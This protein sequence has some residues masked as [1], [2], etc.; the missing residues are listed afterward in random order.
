M[1]L[2]KLHFLSLFFYVFIC[3]FLSP[4]CLTAVAATILL[5]WLAVNSSND[6]DDDDGDSVGD[7]AGV[8]VLIDTGC[9][10]ENLRPKK[11]RKTIIFNDLV[12]FFS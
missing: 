6:D 7:D 3:F 12:V 10:L 8:G 1:T 2:I 4:L 5:F 9:C 11:L